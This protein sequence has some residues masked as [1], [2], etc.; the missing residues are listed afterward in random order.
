MLRFSKILLICA[1]AAWGFLGAMH[2]LLDWPGTLGAVGAVTSMVTVEGGPDKWQA[3]SSPVLAWLGALFI[4]L[5]KLTAAILCTAGAISMSRA[6][7]GPALAFA[8]AKKMA[9]A[10]CG[11]AMFM[12]F[13]G[14]VVIADGFFEVWNSPVMRDPVLG[15]A[16][17]YGAMIMLIGIFVGATDD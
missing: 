10:G 8:Q 1:V 2:N 4:C 14:F 15:S 7:T 13:G 16:F 11:V 6:R 3:V 9:L 17:R 5:S 12:L